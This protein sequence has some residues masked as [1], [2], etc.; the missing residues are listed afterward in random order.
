MNDSLASVFFA[1]PIVFSFLY[2]PS[3]FLISHSYSSLVD[4]VELIC[5]F[6]IFLLFC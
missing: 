2:A 4:H 1:K 6:A 3:S 5:C